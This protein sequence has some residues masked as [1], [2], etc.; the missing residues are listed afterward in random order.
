[1]ASSPSRKPSKHQ[2]GPVARTLL[3]LVKLGLGAGLLLALL[4]VVA[5]A[6]SMASL[7]GYRE[8]MRSPNGQAIQVRAA[9]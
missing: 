4:L 7:P 8:L 9:G 2:R 5:V 3:T 1:M 6:I